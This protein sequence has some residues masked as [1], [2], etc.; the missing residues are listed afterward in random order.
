MWKC[1]TLLVQVLSVPNVSV[2]TQNPL[3]KE[4]FSPALPQAPLLQAEV[5]PPA[6]R[7]EH[8]VMDSLCHWADSGSYP[9][10]AEEAGLGRGYSSPKEGKR[11]LNK[12]SREKKP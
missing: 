9:L 8:T 1:F 4:A 7:L 2:S 12:Q 3:E 11:A 10:P 5:C 6:R